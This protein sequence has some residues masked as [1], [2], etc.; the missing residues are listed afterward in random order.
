VN[1]IV[2]TNGTTRHFTINNE[3]IIVTFNQITLGGGY[4]YESNG[5]SIQILSN[6]VTI[7][8]NDSKIL[9]NIAAYA[10]GSA[11][12][13]FIYVT[14]IDTHIFIERSELIGNDGGR[15]GGVGYGGTWLIQNSIVSGNRAQQ[16]GVG[17]IGAYTIR[18]SLLIGNSAASRGG[19]GAG[20]GTTWLLENNTILNNVVPG[21]SSLFGGAVGAEGTWTVI[22]NIFYGN[23]RQGVTEN[24]KTG[25]FA[26]AG[27][28]SY[29]IITPLGNLVNGGNNITSDPNPLFTNASAGDFSLQ[30]GSP[31]IDVGTSNVSVTTDILNVTRPQGIAYEMGAF[32]FIPPPSTEVYLSPTGNDIT[33]DGSV[34]NPYETVAKG[35]EQVPLDGTIYLFPGVFT[36]N[37]EVVVTKSFTMQAYAGGGATSVNAIVTTNGTT[38]HFYI[39]SANT[40]VT[41]NSITLGGGYS[42]V[43]G[44]SIYVNNSAVT[45]SFNNVRLLENHAVGD[46][47]FIYIQ[48]GAQVYLNDSLVSGNFADQNAGFSYSGNWQVNRS[49]FSN[50]RANYGGVEISGVWTVNESLFVSN[51]A[52][53]TAGISYSSN[54]IVR[55]SVFSGNTALYGA[56]GAGVTWLVENSTF[57]NNQANTGGSIGE[58]TWTI[59]NS[60]FYSNSA[61]GYFTGFTNG[62]IEYSV[63]YAGALGNLTDNGNNITANPKFVDENNNDYRLSFLSPAINTATDNVT[64]TRDI[65]NISRPK[66][67]N[68]DIGAYEYHYLL[69]APLTPTA[70]QTD[71][72]TDSILSIHLWDSD[73]NIVTTSIQ[74]YLDGAFITPVITGSK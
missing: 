37:A 50:N 39:A 72:P 29:S 71:V 13:G 59:K 19:V 5:G 73:Y 26:A 7:N 25:F 34:G 8:I 40:S 74:V 56:V 14:S 48:S 64:V 67:N 30:L 44:G 65:Q 52:S 17:N 27:N 38:R 42:N 36:M 9:N 2:T 10:G 18:N 46:A 32:E 55:N 41:F 6:A 28:V 49:I 1:A 23:K 54:W 60:I 47:G 66:F 15:T 35:Y 21:T 16:G 62:T 33:G 58:G 61:Q 69:T 4:V 11:R 53:S 3:N 57:A 70:N 31:A 43:N 68:Y 51:N 24:F 20:S 12:G 22:N 45:L 63:V